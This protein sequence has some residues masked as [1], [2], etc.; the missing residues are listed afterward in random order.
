MSLDVSIVSV[1]CPPRLHFGPLKLHFRPLKL[2]RFDFHGD[3]DLDLYPAF[4]FNADLDPQPCSHIW[5][6]HGETG[7]QSLSIVLCSLAKVLEESWKASEVKERH[8]YLE[9]R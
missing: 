2:L 5:T 1:H 3:P 8:K 7:D 4:H 9:M 6:G